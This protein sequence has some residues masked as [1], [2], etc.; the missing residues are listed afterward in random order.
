MGCLISGFQDNNI[1]YNQ[2]QI[3]NVSGN[4]LDDEEYNNFYEDNYTN[5]TNYFD[6]LYR[7]RF[8]TYD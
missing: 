1:E 6:T 2:N 7:R 8:C 4:Y 3:D 5:Y